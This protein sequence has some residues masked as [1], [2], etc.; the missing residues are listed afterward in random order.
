MTSSLRFAFLILQIVSTQA[1]SASA[2][3]R[4]VIISPHRQSIQREVVPQFEAHYLKTYG[5]EIE[6]EWIDQGGTTDD[7]R[8]IKSRFSQ[9]PKTAHMD[10]FWGGGELPFRDLKELGLLQS[11]KLSEAVTKNIPND[12]QGIPLKDVDNTWHGISLSTFGLF[13]NKRLLKI[14]KL[15]EPK[16]WTDLTDPHWKDLVSL[17]DPR[18]SGTTIAIQL[19]LVEALGWDK[20]WDTLTRTAV[21]TRLFTHS[22]TEPVSAVVSGDAAVSASIDFFGYS[23]VVELGTKKVGYTNGLD[24]INLDVDP[25]AVL[26]GAPNTT[27]AKR[28][29]E[30]LISPEAQKR[31]MLQKGQPEGPQYSTLGRMAVNQLAWEKAPS[32]LENPFKIQDSLERYFSPETGALLRPLL[33][34]MIGAILVDHHQ[35]LRE[36]WDHLTKKKAPLSE[37]QALT[38]PLI[39]HD[40]ALKLAAS[41]SKDNVRNKTIHSWNEQAYARYQKAL[42]YGKA[43]I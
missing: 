42:S 31:L 27:G 21:N 19:G 3:E 41:W 7:L 18:R 36:S 10:I 4:L 20:G 26:K 6:V 32:F 12:C 13:Y 22:S 8:F 25:I 16:Q 15:P 37:F 43:S 14:R 5:H 17:A 2:K 38:A 40:E 39:T 29:I 33:G 23:K 9:S 11:V 28:F 1:F 34:D 35:M 30:Y 24:S